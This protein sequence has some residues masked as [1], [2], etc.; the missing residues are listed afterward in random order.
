MRAIFDGSVGTGALK[1]A[2]LGLIHRQVQQLTISTT[3]AM[4]LALKFQ[5]LSLSLRRRLK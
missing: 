5:K 1:G 2:T 3:Q 4:L